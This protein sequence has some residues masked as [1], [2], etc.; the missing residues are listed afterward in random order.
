MRTRTPQP[1]IS[2]L[3]EPAM[4]QRERFKVSIDGCEI[5]AS[6][7]LSIIEAVWRAGETLVEGVGCMQG[8]CGSCRVVVRRADSDDVKLEMACETVVEPG[9]QVTFVDFVGHPTHYAYDIEQFQDAWDV[10]KQINEVFHEAAHCRHCGDGR[11]HARG[12]RQG[13][14]SAAEKC[15]RRTY[16]MRLPPE[17]GRACPVIPPGSGSFWFPWPAMGTTV[18]FR[19]R[20]SLARRRRA[21]ADGRRVRRDAA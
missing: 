17:M 11:A 1:E 13:C 2:T 6:A 16:P 9:M 21:G 10:L 14:S 5:E 7:G 20:S 4:A 15:S 8:V 12:G 19:R 18:P 3:Q